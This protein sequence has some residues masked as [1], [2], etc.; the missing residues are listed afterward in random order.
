MLS[1]VVVG[2]LLSASLLDLLG[3][4]DDRDRACD[5]QLDG[6]R[7]SWRP[8]AACRGAAAGRSGSTETY[9]GGH[10]SFVK[11]AGVDAAPAITCHHIV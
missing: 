10:L 8:E 6:V 3:G 5:L 4:D 9:L 7:G 2:T 11:G 1:D